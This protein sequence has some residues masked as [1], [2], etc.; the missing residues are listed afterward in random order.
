MRVQPYTGGALLHAMSQLDLQIILV[1]SCSML[2]Q[3][4]LR[5]GSA[6]YCQLR[7]GM[8]QGA[9]SVRQQQVQRLLQQHL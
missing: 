1:W 4:L 2:M 7:H 9:T 5:R 3:Q 6:L 8:Q